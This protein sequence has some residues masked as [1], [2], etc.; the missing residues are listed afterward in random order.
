[1]SLSPVPTSQEDEQDIQLEFEGLPVQGLRLFVGSLGTFVCRD[2]EGQALE[3]H[4]GDTVAIQVEVQVKGVYTGAGYKGRIQ[5]KPR[6]RIHMTQVLDG[7]QEVVGVTRR[8][9]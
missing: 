2:D 8:P 6:N 9:V 4:E 3:L 5:V 7:T 1:M